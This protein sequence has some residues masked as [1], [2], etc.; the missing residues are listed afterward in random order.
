MMDYII[1]LDKQL[2]FFLNGLHTPWLDQVMF[3]V[4]DKKIWIPF[5]LVLA[6]WIIKTFKWKSLIFLAAIGLT[7]TI[8]DQVISGFM[9]GFF[10]RWRPSRDPALENMVHTVN[11]YSGGSYGFASSHS[12]NTFALAMFIHLL[13]KEYKWTWLMFVWA[14]VVAYSRVYLGVHYPGDIIV[15]GLIGV[16]V[17]QSLFYVSQKIFQRYF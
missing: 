3:W 2:F 14:G 12:G 10:E 17:A 4:S 8:T 15:G 5:Y 16:L 1:E 7:I 6:G 13:F 11:G 9:K